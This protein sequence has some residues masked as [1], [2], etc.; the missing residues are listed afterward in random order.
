MPYAASFR[1]FT[2]CPGSFPLTQPIYRCPKCDGLLDVVH[3]HDALRDRGP[4]AWMKL[5]DER[6][7][8]TA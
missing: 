3:D 1:C 6:Y 2:G 8:R 4:A 7:K 5:F